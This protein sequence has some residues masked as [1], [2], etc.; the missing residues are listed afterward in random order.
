MLSYEL[1]AL[2]DQL[3]MAEEGDGVPRPSFLRMPPT[4]ICMRNPSL[5]RQVSEERTSLLR[6]AHKIRTASTT[7]KA[8][9]LIPL[10]KPAAVGADFTHL[11][12]IGCKLQLEE[13]LFILPHLEL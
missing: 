5:G 4:T 8:R 12:R 9:G 2:I 6:R 1:Q 7:W 11:L 10:S 3:I 13:G